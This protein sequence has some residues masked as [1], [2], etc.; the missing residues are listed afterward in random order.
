MKYFPSELKYPE[1]MPPEILMYFI[2]QDPIDWEKISKYPWCIDTWSLGCI[3]FE[4]LLGIPFL[5]KERCIIND[6]ISQIKNSIFGV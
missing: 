5:L 1:Y 6:D 2:R 4:I 3:M